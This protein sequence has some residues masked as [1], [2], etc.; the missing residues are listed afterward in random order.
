MPN[1]GRTKQM[2]NG[3]TKREKIILCYT[4]L[5]TIGLIAV[6]LPV[7]AVGKTTVELDDCM[8]THYEMLAVRKQIWVEFWNNLLHSH[9]LSIP[10]VGYNLS[11]DDHLFSVIG[12]EFTDILFLVTQNTQWEFC[13]VIAQAL[14]LWVAGWAFILY[15]RYRRPLANRLTMVFCSLVYVF[16]GFGIVSTYNQPFFVALLYWFP[17]VLLGVEKSIREKKHGVLISAVCGSAVCS[18]YLHYYLTIVLIPYCI[19][20][21]IREK[22]SSFFRHGLRLAADYIIGFGISMF[23]NLHVILLLLSSGKAESSALD[24]GLT[25]GIE[26]IK[27]FA[28]RFFV[29]TSLKYSTRIGITPLFFPMLLYLFTKKGRWIQKTAFIVVIILMNVPLWGSIA[30]ITTTNNRWSF[31]LVFICAYISGS[32]LPELLQDTGIIPKVVITI[33]TIAWSLFLL[34]VGKAIQ[35]IYLETVGI[36]LAYAVTVLSWVIKKEETKWS[37][38]FIGF[39]IC[40][41][42]QMWFLS[43]NMNLAERGKVNDYLD[44]FIDY[45]AAGI[46]DDSFYRV[47]RSSN[48]G[49]FS[50]INCNLPF[51]YGFTGISSFR[52]TANASVTSYMRESGNIGFLHN[53]KIAGLDG[54]T[55][56]EILACTKYYLKDDN[57]VT[58]YGFVHEASVVWRN[59]NVLPLGYTYKRTASWDDYEAMNPAEQQELL[60]KAVVLEGAPSEGLP[61]LHSR[62][63]PVETIS[64]QGV[65]VTEDGYSFTKKDGKIILGTQVPE[66]CELLLEMDGFVGNGKKTIYATMSDVIKGAWW[67]G[68]GTNY[69]TRQ[70]RIVFNLGH[71]AAGAQQIEI[72]SP[73]RYFSIKTIRCYARDL[74]GVDADIE[75]LRASSLTGVITSTNRV[76]G[77]VDLPS[78]QWL[79]FSLP[80]S[81]AWHCFV[82]GAERVLT[83]V[84]IM[85][86][87]LTLEPGHHD[88]ELK[89]FPYGMKLGILV[90]L[91]CVLLWI[92]IPITGRKRKRVPSRK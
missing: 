16:S 2:L 52:N 27:S 17:F 57:A 75:Q 76:S 31:C 37:L 11:A 46:T 91:C 69:S 10:F 73:Q 38:V 78:E 6:F 88:I 32:M 54:K 61:A 66:N 87:G 65:K 83:K 35:E 86:M 4:A 79:V 48:E 71:D 26:Y 84:N 80:Y 41:N 21:L 15:Y 85:Y 1:T 44:S 14:R 39:V 33:G 77:E 13:F 62:E 23:I 8:S 40:S 53:A 43:G 60:L 89:Y 28:T 18:L 50:E 45:S 19:I 29:N 36:L 82:D 9:K 72:S 74:S 81:R 58:P 90:S 55:T 68:E 92:A 24:F 70:T 7:F 59:E 56:D 47:D 63:L 12:I 51:W 34:I 64:V 25:Y 42:L 30:G 22:P 67:Y 49:I 5:F 20:R 3:P